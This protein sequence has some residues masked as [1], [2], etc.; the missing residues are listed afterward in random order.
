[1]SGPITGAARTEN[2]NQLVPNS[3]DMAALDAGPVQPFA[4]F[5]D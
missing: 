3:Y 1:M 4:S 5:D 2:T